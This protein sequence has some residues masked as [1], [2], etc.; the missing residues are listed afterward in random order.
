MKMEVQSAFNKQPEISQSV[1]YE[2][3]SVNITTRLTSKTKSTSQGFSSS[4]IKKK[5][6]QIPLD[7]ISEI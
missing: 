7:K 6:P 5:L 1:R 2:N 4:V 3:E